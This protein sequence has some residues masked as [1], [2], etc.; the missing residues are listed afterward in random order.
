MRAY[1]EIA[2]AGVWDCREL[3]ESDLQEI[4]EFRRANI[5]KWLENFGG[6][7]WELLY[8][9]RDFHAVCDDIDIPWATEEA[10]Q[11]W[12]E[13]YP[14][15]PP[16]PH[17]PWNV[18]KSAESSFLQAAL[19]AGLTRMSPSC[20]NE[21]YDKQVERKKQ[22]LQS[23]LEAYEALLRDPRCVEPVLR[24]ELG[25]RIIIATQAEAGIMI[26]RAQAEAAYD[27]RR[28]N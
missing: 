10:R 6:L 22:K 14:N 4:G 2:G 19:D 23:E 28:I 12:A 26:S 3:Q 25:V 16:E 11:G 17:L 20:G 24:R 8:P 27:K 1:I 18:W 5:A 21:N 13:V 15:G 9:I 7:G